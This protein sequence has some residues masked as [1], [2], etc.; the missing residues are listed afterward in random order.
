M[1][2]VEHESRALLLELRGD[3][4]FIEKVSICFQWQKALQNFAPANNPR[5]NDVSSLK[6]VHSN[7]RHYDIIYD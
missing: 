6:S 3:K 5:I 1:G 2:A 4:V 7:L